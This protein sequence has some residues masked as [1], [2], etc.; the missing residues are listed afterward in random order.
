MWVDSYVCSVGI[1]G[2]RMM[3]L[4]PECLWVWLSNYILLVPGRLIREHP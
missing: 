2:R 4:L 1:D 3:V